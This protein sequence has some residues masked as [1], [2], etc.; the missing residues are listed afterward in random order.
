PIKGDRIQLQQV[1]MNL[2]VNAMDAMAGQ[3]RAERR[4]TIWTSHIENW[5]EVSIADAGPGIPRDNIRQIFEPF[6]TTKPQ[7]MGMGLSIARTIV[8]AHGGQI[9]AANETGRGA[10]FV[11]RLPLVSA[12]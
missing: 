3:S 6:F 2:I 4:I 1:I 8:E 9:S 11:I 5:A 10:V 7:G 12:E